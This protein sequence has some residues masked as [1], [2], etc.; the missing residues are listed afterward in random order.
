MTTVERKQEAIRIHRDAI[1]VDGMSNGRMSSEYFDKMLNG[2]ITASMVPVTI[3]A[4]F[5]ETIRRLCDLLNL[6]E[7]SFDR[8]SI[9]KKTDDILDAKRQGKLGLILVLE[10]SRQLEDDIDLLKI[11]RD[12][13]VR[14]M[15]LVY[16]IQNSAGCGKGER[17]DSG[18]SKF[19][20]KLIEKME[21]LGILIDLCHA[22]P[23]TL[24]E[25]MEVI[26]KPAVFSHANVQGVYG[27]RN[28]QTDEDLE[29]LARN[30][31]VIGIAGGGG[32]W[33]V[34][35]RTID[36][37][38]DHI[39][40]VRDRIGIDYVG[41]GLAIF[42]GH[43]PEFYD[44]FDLPPEIFGQW[45]RPPAKGIESIELFGNFTEKLV[46][47]GYSEADIKKVLGENFLRVLRNVW[48]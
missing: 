27:H 29:W 11:F 33:K 47:R 1:V 23:K 36:R 2:G 15:Q 45:P 46:E 26:R 40:Y 4:P 34:A 14:R 8:V 43:S 18:L 38:V 6:V 20:V 25:A 5:R 28:N 37:I 10:D 48:G 35:E 42:E 41:I 19:G 9:V 16:T 39:D 21:E 22:A 44:Q 3:S 30:G 7:R 24:K 32:A 31:G 17:H 12:L 13:G